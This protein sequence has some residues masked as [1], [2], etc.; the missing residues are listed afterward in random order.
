[1]ATPNKGV[2]DY[3]IKV[4]VTG[5]IT[6]PRTSASVASAIKTALEALGFG[7]GASA[8][9]TAESSSST[10]GIT[11]T[12]IPQHADAATRQALRRSQGLTPG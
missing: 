12:K 1:M 5:V 11:T 6:A 8:N 2:I 4:R 7:A 10:L 3:A 9:V